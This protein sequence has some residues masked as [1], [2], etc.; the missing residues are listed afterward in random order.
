MGKETGRSTEKGLLGGGEGN[1]FQP[2]RMLG[3]QKS[4]CV[5]V[6]VICLHKCVCL[7]LCIGV[8]V[9][10]Y[11]HAVHELICAHVYQFVCA[12]LCMSLSVYLCAALSFCVFLCFC[13]CLSVATEVNTCVCMSVSV[14]EDVGSG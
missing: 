8:F 4:M 14:G 1:R 2:V 6:Y 3:G 7:Y 11:T 9:Y 10:I 13:A 12:H 5:E